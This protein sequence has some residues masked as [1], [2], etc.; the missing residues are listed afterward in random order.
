[1]I[2][3]MSTVHGYSVAHSFQT[4]EN[5]AMIKAI[6]WLVVRSG[7]MNVPIF[8]LEVCFRRFSGVD[9]AIFAKFAY[10]TMDVCLSLYPIVIIS[11]V[12]I[13]D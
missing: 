11:Y 5:I 9:S 10:T 1:S 2:R 12:P 13:V 7:L 8:V 4:K 6:L 3:A